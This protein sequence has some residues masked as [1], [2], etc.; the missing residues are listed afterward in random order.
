MTNKVT[1]IIHAHRLQIDTED[2]WE[3]VD[4]YQEKDVVQEKQTVVDQHAD[5]AGA[6]LCLDVP[7][8]VTRTYFVLEKT[9][10][11]VITEKNKLI[12]SLIEAKKKLK[13]NVEELKKNLQKLSDNLKWWQDK[14]AEIEKR[15]ECA[16]DAMEKMAANLRKYEEDFGCLR[17]ALGTQKMDAILGDKCED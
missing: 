15:E 8:E 9:G 11:Q 16:N 13:A 7:V 14:C 12:K 4:R 6:T 2:G 17:A 5:Y 1:K 10:D 3:V